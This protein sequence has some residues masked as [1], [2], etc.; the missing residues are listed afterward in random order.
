MKS[1]IRADPYESALD[2]IETLLRNRQAIPAQ[3]AAMQL[4]A[5]DPGRAEG[6]LLLGRAF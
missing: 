6:Y 5:A 3:R 4:T 2:R 1:D